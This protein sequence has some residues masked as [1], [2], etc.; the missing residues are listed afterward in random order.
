[1]NIKTGGSIVVPGFGYSPTNGP[2]ANGA[3]AGGSYG[4]EGY[5][6]TG[7]TYG[8]YSAPVNLGSGGGTGFGGGAVILNVT[9][10]AQ[11]DGNILA[12]GGASGAYPGAGG[13]IFITAS[14]LSGAGTLTAVGSPLLEARAPAAADVSPSS[15]PP[16]AGRA[17]FETTAVP[18]PGG[19]NGAAGTIFIQAPGTNGTL[20]VDNN[21]VIS[22]RATYLG[23]AASSGSYTFDSI[24]S[25]RKSSVIFVSFSTV[26][27]AGA[28]VFGDGDFTSTVTINGNLYGGVISNVTS[29]GLTAT[30]GSS[31]NA[32]SQTYTLDA[33]TAS[34]Y[35]GTLISSVTLNRNAT[36]STLAG[37]TTYY[38]R[39][40]P[41]GYAIETGS[42][43]NWAI[44]G[45]TCTLQQSAPSNPLITNVYVSSLTAAW[46]AASGSAG[47]S[48]EASTMAPSPRG[49]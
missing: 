15:R 35:T 29:G 14:A 19:N 38:L 49:R 32:S 26:A 28:N 43:N 3:T 31:P 18:E 9:N 10:T 20:T 40:R 45:S 46:G 44:L 17:R 33:S 5:S 27:I 47:Y 11:V 4:G 30:W 2:G 8:S 13:S 21:N 6:G 24:L 1:M 12:D 22:P 48:L 42:P 37:G 16:A 25:Q 34:N 41:S 23:T 39:V 7:K 36:L